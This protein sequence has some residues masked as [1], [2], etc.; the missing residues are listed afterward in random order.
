MK[1]IYLFDFDGVISD[2]RQELFRTS[3][4]AYLN[5][6]D[7]IKIKL[8]LKNFKKTNFNKEFI[9]N[10]RFANSASG[11]FYL[12]NKIFVQKKIIHKNILSKK[13]TELEYKKEFYK[14]RKILKNKD[15]DRWIKYHKINQTIKNYINKYYDKRDIFIISAKDKE[16]LKILIKKNNIKIKQSNLISTSKYGNKNKIFND[17]AKKYKK[18]R[19]ILF[20][21]NIDNIKT[22][23][24]YNFLCYYA[25]WYAGP[26]Q[27]NN[28]KIKSLSIEGLKKILM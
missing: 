24:K 2:S 23:I 27:K 12:W 13:Y 18:Y 7:K 19:I 5:L 22:G 1:K 15:I 17:I 11:F 20:E 25:N 9:K 26:I 6:I 28:I 14:Y 4:K 3:L 21:D 8:V 10:N 16:S